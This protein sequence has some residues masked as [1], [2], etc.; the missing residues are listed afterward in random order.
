MQK[1][2]ISIEK[3]Y[4]PLQNPCWSLHVVSHDGV[5]TA[6]LSAQGS[7]MSLFNSHKIGSMVFV[8]NRVLKDY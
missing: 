8:P 2:L 5:Q 3:L 4:N 7:E 6:R 1:Q